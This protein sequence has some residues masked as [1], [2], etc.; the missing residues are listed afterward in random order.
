MLFL[1]TNQTRNKYMSKMM[2]PLLTN[3][4]QKTLFYHHC[5]SFGECHN[6]SKAR[7]L[8]LW[9]KVP[10]KSPKNHNSIVPDLVCWY[11]SRGG[12]WGSDLSCYCIW[13]TRAWWLTFSFLVVQS[14][15]H[16]HYSCI[17]KIY[18]IAYMRHCKSLYLKYLIAIPQV[19][20]LSNLGQYIR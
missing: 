15:Q 19:H 3:H 8:I 14:H 20:M 18:K 4:K 5:N 9:L 12:S 11:A 16:V 7:T 6:L 13:L 10:R 17:Q 1:P 2:S